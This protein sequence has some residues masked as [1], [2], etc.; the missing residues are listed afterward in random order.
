MR[1]E[2]GQSSEYPVRTGVED[3]YYY[4]KYGRCFFG[5]S[6]RFNH[7][8]VRTEHKLRVHLPQR[9]QMRHDTVQPSAYQVHLGA[10]NCEQYLQTGQC[11]HG[12]KCWLNHP[13]VSEN[14]KKEYFIELPHG[15]IVFDTAS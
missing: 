12:R 11:S 1:H 2:L 15:L 6:C 14:T 9:N 5:R 4:Q 7:P 8:A 3:C 13:T 10:T